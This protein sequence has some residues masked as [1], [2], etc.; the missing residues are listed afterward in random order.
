[1][2]IRSMRGRRGPAGAVLAPQV[3]TIKAGG[4]TLL[5]IVGY[6][7]PASGGPIPADGMYISDSGYTADPAQATDIQGTPGITTVMTEESVVEVPGQPGQ[8]GAT[9]KSAYQRAVDLGQTALSEADWLASL[10]GDPGDPGAPGGP[11]RAPTPDEIAT[12]AG[13]YIAA[14][15]PASGAPGATVDMRVSGGQVQWRRVGDAGWTDLISVAALTG[16]AGGNGTNGTN[17]SAGAAGKNVQLQATATMIQWRLLGDSTWID[18]VALSALKGAPGDPGA[19]GAAGATLVGSVTLGQTAGIAIA[20]GI[21]EVS[22]AMAG[23][24]VGA[25]YIA[26]CDSYRLNGGASTPGRPAGY[27]II[28]CVCNVAGTVIISINAPLLAIGASY[29]LTCSIV[30]INV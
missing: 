17:G 26:F 9:G 28:D 10:K 30:R 3:R 19:A 22:V 20:L 12:A 7:P 18:L 27:A 11:G 1:M 23:A 25:R 4:R 5:K 15:P 24:V 2:T 6:L 29:A 21:R 8:D 13:N 14:H 16:P